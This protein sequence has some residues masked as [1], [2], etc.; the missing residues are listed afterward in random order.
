MRRER[1]S[2]PPQ[3]GRT[4][5]RGQGSRG[6]PP[7]KS[8]D[9]AKR[10]KWKRIFADLLRESPTR[11]KSEAISAAVLLRVPNEKVS[12]SLVQKWRAPNDNRKL[13][14]ANEAIARAL[15]DA[16]DELGV[17][18]SVPDA[19]AKRE[20]LLTELGYHAERTTDL[21]YREIANEARSKLLEILQHEGKDVATLDNAERQLAG[22]CLLTQLQ[23]QESSDPLKSKQGHLVMFLIWD[24]RNDREANMSRNSLAKELK[25]KGTLKYLRDCAIAG[26]ATHVVFG[27]YRREERTD[28]MKL[29]DEELGSLARVLNLS[30]G[31]NR[32]KMIKVWGR[33]M[34]AMTPSTAYDVWI[35][36]QPKGNRRAWRMVRHR[37]LFEKIDYSAAA[38]FV[39]PLENE[40]LD[41]LL[42]SLG[43]EWSDV[44]ED[45]VVQ[46]GTQIE[47]E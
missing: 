32:K 41:S 39:S 21:L 18:G 44:N 43:I 25:D 9:V 17:F 6:R 45:W 19:T 13:A 3:V 15:V 34:S 46:P 1:T 38:T 12:A 47:A 36:L 37:Q 42:P 20:K 10:V 5:E 35:H 29:C 16:L 11:P 30:S 4:P 2:L 26:V 14:P 33:E 24:A 27:V 7:L 28:G 40:R 8:D 22:A 31:G 23:F